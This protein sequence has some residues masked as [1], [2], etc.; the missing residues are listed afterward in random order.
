MDTP[1]IIANG[2]PGK[3]E[4]AYRAGMIAMNFIDVGCWVLDVGLVLSFE[5]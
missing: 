3:R 1:F 5:F 4:E 2:F